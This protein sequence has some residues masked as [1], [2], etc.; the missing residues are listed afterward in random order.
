MSRTQTYILPLNSYGLKNNRPMLYIHQHWWYLPIFMKKKNKK[1]NT[2]FSKDILYFIFLLTHSGILFDL[3]CNLQIMR[4]APLV[5]LCLLCIQHR[6]HTYSHTVHTASTD[7]SWWGVAGQ[8][9][10]QEVTAW[11]SSTCTW[12]WWATDTHPALQGFNLPSQQWLSFVDRGLPCPFHVCFTCPV[13]KSTSEEESQMA[14]V[15]HSVAKGGRVNGSQSLCW[16]VF[17]AH[18][19]H[20]VKWDLVH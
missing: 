5:S 20:A 7:L 3:K 1:T 4:S 12:A 15:Y 9:H 6:L 19:R 8:E 14:G 11:G 18:G 13:L 17:Q 16:L 2:H 10:L